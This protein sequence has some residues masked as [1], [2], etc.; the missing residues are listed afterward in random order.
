MSRRLGTWRETGEP[1]GHFTLTDFQYL[2]TAI[3]APFHPF[4]PAIRMRISKHSQKGKIMKT[5]IGTYRIT[6]RLFK[7]WRLGAQGLSGIF[8]WM[9]SLWLDKQQT[10]IVK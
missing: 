7:S 3:R 8:F 10:E 2:L 4:S 6:F 5:R 1:S 9:C